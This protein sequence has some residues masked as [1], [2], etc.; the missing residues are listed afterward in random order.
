MYLLREG[1]GA[2]AYAN[3]GGEFIYTL[4][5]S[6]ETSKYLRN[7]DDSIKEDFR[8]SSRSDEALRGIGFTPSHSYNGF[9]H[10]TDPTP[11][12]FTHDASDYSAQV[13]PFY[14]D[15][16]NE[17]VQNPAYEA[18]TFEDSIFKSVYECLVPPSI[19]NVSKAQFQAQNYIGDIV[20]PLSTP[21]ITQMAQSVAIVQ[22]FRQ[23]SA[24]VALSLVAL[25]ATYAGNEGL[26]TCNCLC[27]PFSRGRGAFFIYYS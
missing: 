6:H 23:V 5:C 8:E 2:D 25:F 11:R 15:G 22:C 17:I 12:R 13:P 27:R 4:I 20:E 19:T 21:L 3:N 7:A 10:M 18:A 26:T 14:K 16:N 1:A 9:V 24:L